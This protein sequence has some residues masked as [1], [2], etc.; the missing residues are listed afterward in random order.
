MKENIHPEDYRP[1]VFED[2]ASGARFL[3]GSTVHTT[4]STKWE[5]GKKYP[6]CTVEISSKSHPFYTGED[7]MLDKAGRVERFKQRAA[8]KK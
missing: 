5:D 4:E 2:L 1:V 7:R 3:I 8:K 6:K